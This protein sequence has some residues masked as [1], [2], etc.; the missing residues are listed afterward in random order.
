MTI[1]NQY[2]KARQEKKKGKRPSKKTHT[3]TR[4]FTFDNSKRVCGSVCAESTLH[5]HLP[6][7]PQSVA[8]LGPAA[9]A[10][11]DKPGGMAMLV[12]D[13]VRLDGYTSLL[14]CGF[15][16]PTNSGQKC[17]TPTATTATI[18]RTWSYKPGPLGMSEGACGGQTGSIPR[19]SSTVANWRALH[20]TLTR[21]TT[22]TTKTPQVQTWVRKMTAWPAM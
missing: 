6:V 1:N 8:E 19:S 13:S 3:R 7:L 12:L 16:W 10:A 15:Y 18:I 14:G 9:Q 2:K 20:S 4:T 11:A 21:K 17:C 5:T 22:A